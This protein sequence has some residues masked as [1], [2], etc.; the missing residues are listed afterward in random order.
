[1]TTEIVRELVDGEW[2]T[3]VSSGGG[4]SS[5]VLSATVTVTNA[6]LLALLMTPVTIVAAPGAGKA[7]F[8]VQAFLNADTTGGAYTVDANTIVEIRIP[9]VSGSMLSRL[10]EVYNGGVSEL[11]SEGAP[12][13]AWMGTAAYTDSTSTE[14][15]ASS[16]G[17]DPAELDD[18]PLSLLQSNG[19]ALIGGNAANTLTVTA[20][21]TVV[22]L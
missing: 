11:L 3:G 7:I 1:V 4:G 20:Y 13:Y 15:I 8:P 10:I 9:A 18:Q 14:T 17:R 12:A 22:T 6:Q 5:S 16:P 2:V 21:Y 19:A